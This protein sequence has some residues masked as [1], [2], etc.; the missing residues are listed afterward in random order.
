M[1]ES[2][3]VEIA[4]ETG[5]LDPRVVELLRHAA[6]VVLDSEAPVGDVE[7]SL[8]LLDDDG[9]S[10]INEESLSHQGPTDVI[11]FPLGHPGLPLLG[12]IYV[13]VDQAR[14]QADEFGV[15]FEEELVRL[16]VHGVLHILGWLHSESDD[17]AASPMYVRQEEIVRRVL[18]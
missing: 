9:I 1:A 12:D 16:V 10:R 7:V 2:R 18:S 8:A 4:D 3:L 13:G 14:R 15:T 6:V 5:T 17:R 11:S